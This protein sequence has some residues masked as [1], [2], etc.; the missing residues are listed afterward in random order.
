MEAASAGDCWSA[1]I[2]ESV[3]VCRGPNPLARKCAQ[4][5]T[6]VRLERVAMVK[7]TATT[8]IYWISHRLNVSKAGCFGVAQLRNQDML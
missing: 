2:D 7:A 4:Y 3:A 6:H 1:R 8:H 5:M